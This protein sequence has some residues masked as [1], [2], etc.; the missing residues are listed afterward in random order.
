MNTKHLGPANV[1]AFIVRSN[2]LI[3]RGIC[4]MQQ[5]TGVAQSALGMGNFV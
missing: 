1:C 3:Y 4:S 2:C 5:H